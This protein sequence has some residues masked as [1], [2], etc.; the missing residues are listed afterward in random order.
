LSFEILRLVVGVNDQH[1]QWCALNA[2]VDNVQLF[3]FKEMDFAKA[4]K[5]Q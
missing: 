3:F 4:R 1:G 2:L 5:L